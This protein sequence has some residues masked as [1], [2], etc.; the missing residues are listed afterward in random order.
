MACCFF[1]APNVLTAARTGSVGWNDPE[2]TAPPLHFF[3]GAQGDPAIGLYS[4]QYT[5]TDRVAW[6]GIPGT[7]KCYIEGLCNPQYIFYHRGFQMVLNTW[8]EFR[9]LFLNSTAPLLTAL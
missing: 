1:L 3:E 7:E 6:S 2:H 8:R 9:E 5:A 4:V